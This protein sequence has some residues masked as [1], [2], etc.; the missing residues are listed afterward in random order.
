MKNHLLNFIKI[1]LKIYFFIFVKLMSLY[2][3]YFSSKNKNYMYKLISDIVLQETE[4]NILN[5]DIYIQLY[6]DKYPIIFNDSLSDN[7]SDLNKELLNIIGDDFIKKIKFNNLSINS[8]KSNELNNDNYSSLLRPINELKKDKKFLTIQSI[9]R[10]NLSLN[11][12][13]YKYRFD[14]QINN[15][16]IIKIQLPKENNNLFENPNINV[17]I[18]DIIIPCEMYSSQILNKEYISYKPNENNIN[19]IIINSDKI[20]IELLNHLE[21][22]NQNNLK[23]IFQIEMFK[24]IK[25]KNI[26]YLGFQINN[27]TKNDF[28]IDDILG[29]FNKNNQC[30]YSSQIK[31]IKDIFIFTDN[32]NIN[33]DENEKYI[34]KNMS[35]QHKI[36]IIYD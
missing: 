12:F 10:D 22:P 18:N 3:M 36:D 19:K 16:S 24:K 1:S 20:N 11:R 9:K 8:L 17:K 28:Q 14:S 33:L 31:I 5:D 29:I 7:I 27:F 34:C 25:F 2:D 32:L 35:L 6:K 13:K 21:L 15:L 23:D 30:I 26:D 4:K